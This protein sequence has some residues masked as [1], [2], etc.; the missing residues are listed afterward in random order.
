MF[1]QIASVAASEKLLERLVIVLGV[2]A[3]ILG[4]IRQAL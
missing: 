2:I 3:V 4:V 1:E